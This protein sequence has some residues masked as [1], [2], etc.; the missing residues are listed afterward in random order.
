MRPVRFIPETQRSLTPLQ[1]KVIK[2]RLEGEY[3]RAIAKKLN[4]RLGTVKAVHSSAMNRLGLVSI[5]DLARL[6]WGPIDEA[7]GEK[8]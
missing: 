8:R 6:W 2:M 7:I 5:V 3:Y 1:S 4:I